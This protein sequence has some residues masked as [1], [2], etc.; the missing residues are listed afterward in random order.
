MRYE[1]DGVNEL[2]IVLIEEV[3]EFC[4]IFS[5]W[6]G[7]GCFWRVCVYVYVGGKVCEM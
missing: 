7:G 4:R 5:F 3:V 1:R 2:L 6:E